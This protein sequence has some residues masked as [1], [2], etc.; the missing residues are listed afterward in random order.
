[1]LDKLQYTEIEGKSIGYG[2][3]GVEHHMDRVGIVLTYKDKDYSD[4]FRVLNMSASFDALKRD[5]GVTVHGLLSSSF[6]ER[7]TYPF[8]LLAIIFYTINDNR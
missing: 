1:M 5:S 2:V 6:F 3:D 7:Y 8:A 4:V